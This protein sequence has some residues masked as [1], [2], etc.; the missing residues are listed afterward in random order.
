MRC[1]HPKVANGLGSIR[2]NTAPLA[3]DIPQCKYRIELT[4]LC[5][6]IEKRPSRF[7][8]VVP[9]GMLYEQKAQQGSSFNVALVMGRSR[10]LDGGFDIVAG[11]R[12][13]GEFYHRRDV[14]A[15]CRA[16]E[17]SIS[18]VWIW[19]DAKAFSVEMTEL[20]SRRR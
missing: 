4:A 7:C 5:G 15:V 12:S 8:I 9:V 10:P 18:G 11:G 2:N 19:A 14:A 17:P 6:S 16:E 3:P 20:K 13:I 1:R